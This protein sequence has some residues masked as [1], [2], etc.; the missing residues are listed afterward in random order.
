[1]YWLTMIICE[2]PS[3]FPKIP[4]SGLPV[5]ILEAN[6]VHLWLKQNKTRT[7]FF[8]TWS[9]H[10]NMLFHSAEPVLGYLEVVEQ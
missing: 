3:D 10:F 1:M 8:F 7:M 4:F 5:N 6:L 2:W 9:S